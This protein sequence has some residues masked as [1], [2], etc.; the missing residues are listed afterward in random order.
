MVLFYLAG[1]G[2]WKMIVPIFTEATD[3]EHANDKGKSKRG[4][5]SR[6]SRQ[7]LR[8]RRLQSVRRLR[9]AVR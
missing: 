7:T 3:L 5:P 6:R 8:E 2:G 1:F 4:D 9:F